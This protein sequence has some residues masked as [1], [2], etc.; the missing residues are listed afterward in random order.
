MIAHCEEPGGKGIECGRGQPTLVF[1]FTGVSRLALELLAQ[2]I[3][4]LRQTRVGSGDHPAVSVIHCG[5]AI[6]KLAGVVK[7]S[8]V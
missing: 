2:L 5:L 8:G 1:I 3:Q 7:E 4:Q 6:W